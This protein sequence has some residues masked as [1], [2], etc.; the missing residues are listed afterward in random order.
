MR[1]KLGLVHPCAEFGFQF[2][3]WLAR[4]WASGIREASTPCLELW[5]RNKVFDKAYAKQQVDGH[6][7]AVD[8]FGSYAKKGD[9]AALKAFAQKTA[10]GDSTASRRGEETAPIGS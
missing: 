9:N 1:P 8:L 4:R 7:E 5:P 3:D 10:A 2:G 6:Q